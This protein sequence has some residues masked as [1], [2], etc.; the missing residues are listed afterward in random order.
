LAIVGALFTAL[1]LGVL[2]FHPFSHAAH[3]SKPH[4]AEVKLLCTCNASSGN[5]TCTCY[6]LKLIFRL[7]T[8]VNTSSLYICYV[9]CTY[10]VYPSNY[11][12]VGCTIENCTAVTSFCPCSLPSR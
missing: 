11:T 4:V 2:A 3:S 9:N 6:D 8:A 5:L 7:S 12:R 10:E 1:M